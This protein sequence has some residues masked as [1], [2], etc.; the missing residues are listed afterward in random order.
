MLSVIIPAHNEESLIG[1]CLEALSRSEP[2]AMPAEVIIVANGCSDNTVA[3]AYAQRPR[4]EAAGWAF[5]VIDLAQG[6]KPRALT[7]GDRAANGTIRAYLDA[8]V[9][10]SPGLLPQIVG[11]LDTATPRYAS[12]AIRIVGKG[13]ISRAYARLWA[14]V[15][16]MATTVPGCGFFA[17][18]AAGRARWQDWP[19]V[20]AD[21]LF[22]RLNFAPDERVS[23]AAPYE[24]PIAQGFARLVRVRRRQ[25]AGVAEIARRY[26]ALLGN[27]DKT[28]G[29]ASGLALRDP[30]GFAIYAGVALAVRLRRQGPEWSRSR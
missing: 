2:I 26:P 28:G 22:A 15:P 6:G 24:W 19:D 7:A 18:N 21:D 16:Y 27:E 23:V 4:I 14:K 8:D 25:D 1:P 5:R 20:I 30:V 12:G 3:E 9:T 17:M 13:P 10:V 29:G 11:V